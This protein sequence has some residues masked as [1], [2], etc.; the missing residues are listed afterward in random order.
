ML[1]TNKAFP[2]LILFV[3]GGYAARAQDVCSISLQND[4]T[5]CQGQT[6]LLEGPDGFPTYLW[7]TGAG[8]QDITVSS[9][10][11]YAL[12]VSYP[13]GE[14]VTNG[15]FS[16][17]NTGF[18]TEFTLNNNLNQFE[19]TYWIGT[20]A[21]S[22]HP[23]F[24]GTG[25]GQFMIANSGYE[26]ALFMVWCQ[27]V[28]VC[29][30][31]T[32]TMSFRVRTVSNAT[33]A[34]LQ[35]WMD[36]VPVGPEWNL[37]VFGSGW[38]T[39]NQVWTTP[40]VLTTANICLR[41]MSGEGVGND[42][43]LDDISVSGTIVLTDTV[44]V[45]VTPLPVVDFGPDQ[46]LCFGETLTLNA[47]VSGGSYLWQ[48]GSTAP[49]FTVNSAGT[50]SV[51]VTANNCSST[52]SINVAY[53][54]ALVVELGPDT[55]LCTG[56]TLVLDAT[57]PGGATYLWQDGS[58][59]ATFTVSAPGSYA[60]LVTR[61]GCS[62]SASIAVGYNPLPVVSLGAD[63]SI[64]AGELATLDATT[65][66]GSYLWQD[67]S[68]NA[69]FQADATGTYS[70]DVTV[71]G[72]TSGSSVD[73]T[74]IP[75]PVVDLGGDQII[76]PGSSV[77]FDGTTPG[78][79]YLWQDGNTD[80]NYSATYPGI[81]AVT[82]FVGSC[83]NSDY[84]TLSNYTLPV[85]DL[86]YDQTVC[87]GQAANFSVAVPN[88]TYA[89]STGAITA[90]IAPTTAGTYWVDV[91]RD[92]CTVRDSVQLFVTP[93]PVVDLGTPPAVCPGATVTLDA[94]TAGGSYLWQDGP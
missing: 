59:N 39:I 47:T 6:V 87:A 64:C 40:P 60:V 46:N 30:Q 31:Q 13:S 32:Y 70:V 57:L 86:G 22:H 10:G 14:L 29:P 2:A 88:S 73:V 24:N 21:A 23:Q 68:T 84:A 90:S 93:L 4:T 37:P 81:Y 50:Y 1:L 35:W 66:G 82:V 55:T 67:G 41:V 9:T 7:N 63:Q 43:G 38:Q 83:S 94:T 76:C 78:A 56:A 12:Q 15:D 11:A 54:G 52:E 85:V 17:G 33:P 71:N 8:T 74:V 20:N 19:G 48:D 25:T 77:L 45:T 79:T 42:F 16:A 80:A 44:N 18:T 3:L 91:T 58:T 49:T 69:T 26:A 89:W 75:L 92:G 53:S 65:A 51:T 61:N 28:E 34:R 27:E 72:C 36:G 62:A 5:V